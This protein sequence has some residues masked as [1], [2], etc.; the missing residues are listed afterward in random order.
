M[1][2][3]SVV[4]RDGPFDVAIV[5]VSWNTLD[6]VRSVLAGVA[7]ACAGKRWETVVVDN[8]STD[9]SV[10]HLRQ[11][12]DI[13][14]VALDSNTGFTH[15]A[16]VGVQRTSAPLVLFLNPDVVLPARAVSDLAAVLE[17]HPAAWGVTPCF[18]FPDGRPQHFWHRFPSRMRVVARFTRIG[19]SVDRRIG[20]RWRSY[21]RYEDVDELGGPVT[22]DAA[23][24]ACLL[25]RRAMFDDVG[26]F[27]EAYLNFGQD[28]D[29]ARR[30]RRRGR[31]LLGVPTVTVEHAA[32]V[33]FRKLPRWD[34]EGQL[35]RSVW[36]FLGDEPRRRR[37]PGR[38][39]LYVD[40]W[41]PP[42]AGRRRRRAR[43]R[44]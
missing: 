9:G 31:V 10:A 28:T 19:R 44:G 26:G 16:N 4:P 14:L 2:H 39:L 11:R 18:Q 29:L 8:G 5:L 20:F 36:Q 25:V 41:I 1:A 35:L 3:G 37:W 6:H 17:A 30:Q 24:A 7:A 34:Y 27:D 32:G 40:L 33:T 23:G 22:I 12:D 15:A 43:G 42:E 38:L 21:R 13:E